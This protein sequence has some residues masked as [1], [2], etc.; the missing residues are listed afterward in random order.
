M[1]RYDGWWPTILIN[2]TVTLYPEIS[3]DKNPTLEP[4]GGTLANANRA[5]K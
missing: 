4:N 3:F 1:E 2:R 5:Q